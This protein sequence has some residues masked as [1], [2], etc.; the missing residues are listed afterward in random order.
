L[1][2]SDLS[3]LAE[4]SS[5]PGFGQRTRSQNIQSRLW[6]LV[7]RRERWG[8]SW[9]GWL[10]ITFVVLAAVLGILKN[11]YPFLA[12]TERINANSLVVEGWIHEYAIHAAA[13]EY[14]WGNYEHLF[15]TGGPV[16]GKGGYINDYNTAASVGADLLKHAGVAPAAGQIVP[17]RVS[18]RDRTYSSAVA[19]RDWLLEHNLPVQGVN[20]VT[21]DVHA[22]R[23]RL[24][25]QKA[26]GPDVQIGIIAVRNIDYDETR[27]WHYSESAQQVI[28][29]A[30]AYLYAKLFFHP[31]DAR[32]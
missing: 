3:T 6:G 15:T 17:S 27:W 5:S 26:L 20:I 8:L 21:E 31:P 7:T 11:L 30:V 23:T 12:V 22:R 19:L 24:L 28:G 10:L 1:E 18:G 13:N 2:E 16:V 4:V 25:F 29:E 14:K 32:A 9:C